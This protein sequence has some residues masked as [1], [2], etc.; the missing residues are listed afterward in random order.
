MIGFEHTDFSKAAVSDEENDNDVCDTR[1][2]GRELR[3][4][5]FSSPVV[6]IYEALGL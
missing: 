4:T 1:R 3:L 5:G 2:G 6:M